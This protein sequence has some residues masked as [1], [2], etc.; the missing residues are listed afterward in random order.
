[1]AVVVAIDA[2]TTSVRSIAFD[3]QSAE[4]ASAQSEFPQ[5]FPR[6]GWIEHDPA[7]IWEAVTRTLSELVVCLDGEAIAAIGIAN[8]RETVVLWD[9][10]TGTPLYRAIVWQDRRTSQR[11]RDLE[12][13]GHGPRVQ[14]VTGLVLDPYFSATK[15]EWLAQTLPIELDGDVAFGTIESWL[16]WNLTGGAHHVTDTTN[17]SRTSLLDLRSLRWSEEMLDLFGIPESILPEVRPSTRRIGTTATNLPI[18]AGIP[19]SG[20]AGDQQASL[21]GHGCFAPGEA[22]STFGTG[23][24]VLTNAGATAPDP[25][26][27]LLATV[28]WTADGGATTYALEGSVLATGAAVQWLRDGLGIIGDAAEL[29]DLAAS[30]DSTDDVFFVPALAG[31]G[32]PWWDAD[33]RG[34][35]L[36]LT[37]GTQPA[38]IARA[39]VEAIALQTRDVIE[40]MASQG[41]NISSLRVDGGVA[42]MD[43]L[44]QIQADQLGVP[45]VR[46]ATKETTALGAA[47]LAGLAEGVWSSTEEIAGLM[48]NDVIVEPQPNRVEPERLHVRW[49]EAVERARAWA[50][51]S[52][53]GSP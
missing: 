40:A 5:Y 15:L 6:P 47:Y 28:G 1:M 7:E 26:E 12:E 51:A 53:P 48:R 2:G 29:G 14:E 36:G 39:M 32:S 34:T 38:H 11:C 20:A 18:P 17:A 4:V 3:E 43:L 44:L 19:V 33:A 27:G 35:I 10:A 37:R 22:K 13:L 31:L 41:V 23:S 30:V 42:A 49:L 24:F 9:R 45:V 52:V 46:A 50:R 21:F 16:I 8:Q 25:G